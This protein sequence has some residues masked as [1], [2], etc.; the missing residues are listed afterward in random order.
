[1][2][3]RNNRATVVRLS[4]DPGTWCRAEMLARDASGRPVKV[5]GEGEDWPEAIA[6]A[7]RELLDAK[8]A[9]IV[10]LTPAATQRAAAVAF[11]DNPKIRPAIE[12]GAQILQRARVQAQTA[13]ETE[14]KA[15]GKA[16]AREMLSAAE[17]VAGAAVKSALASYG[18]VGGVAYDAGV[19]VWRQ[20]KKIPFLGRLF[21]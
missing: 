12:Q 20:V 11:L 6:M 16:V 15:A 13:L 9:G 18:P 4:G 10:K 8:R 2:Y 3:N 14:G 1:M 5:S 19:K 21:G 7:A 17:D